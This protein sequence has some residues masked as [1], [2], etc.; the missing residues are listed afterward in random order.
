M[1]LCS[2]GSLSGVSVQGGSLFKGGSMSRVSRSGG[3]CMG[4]LSR[5]SLLWRPPWTATPQYGNN[6]N[7]RVVRTLLE[8]ILVY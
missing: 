7:K 3:L 8:C 6:G 1:G 5:G 4:F 2:G